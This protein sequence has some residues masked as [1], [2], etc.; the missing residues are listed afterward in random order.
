MEMNHRIDDP[1]FADILKRLRSQLL[2][3]TARNRLVKFRYTRRS[4]R[5]ID[6]GI[7]GPYRALL[8]GKTLKLCYVPLPY[9]ESSSITPASYAEKLGISIDYNLNA[10]APAD[11]LQTL[12]YPKDLDRITR[13]MLGENQLSLDETGNHILFLACGFLQYTFSQATEKDSEISTHTAPL[14]MLPVQLQKETIDSES[15]FY[16]FHLAALDTDEEVRDNITLREK[17][18][19]EFGFH[20]PSFKE[21]QSPNEY[22]EEVASG[23]GQ[24]KGWKVFPHLS[25]VLLSFRKLALWTDLDPQQDQKLLDHPLIKKLF[26]FDVKEGGY[27]NEGTSTEY[28]IDEHPLVDMSC[29]YDMDSSQ[30]SALIDALEGKNMVIVGPPGTGKSQTIT[31]L[32]ATAMG[33]RKSVLFVSEKKAALDVV[34]KRLENA[35]VGSFCLELHSNKT[36]K[37]NVIESIGKRLN[38]KFSKLTTDET[39][40]STLKELRDRL[41]AYVNFINREVEIPGNLST[42]NVFWKTEQARQMLECA[43]VDITNQLQNILWP[44]VLQWQTDD[45]RRRRQLLDELKLYHNQLNVSGNL[46]D[47]PLSGLHISSLRIDR[48]QIEGNI[49]FA[50]AA[51][52]NICD[53]SKTI[54]KQDAGLDETDV[55]SIEQYTLYLEKLQQVSRISDQAATFIKG[56]K[57][58]ALEGSSHH[59]QIA[60]TLILSIADNLLES[61][62]LFP[63]YNNNINHLSLTDTYV[64]DIPLSELVDLVQQMRFALDRIGTVLTANRPASQTVSL[65]ALKKFADQLGSNSCLLSLSIAELQNEL[66]N[67]RIAELKTLIAEQ[68]DLA[69]QFKFDRLPSTLDLD[70]HLQLIHGANWWKW[71]VWLAPSTKNAKKV[72]K[73]LLVNPFEAD[74][75]PSANFERL[76]LWCKKRDKFLDE[77]KDM[78]T[79][80]HWWNHA[81]CFAT[82]PLSDKHQNPFPILHGF[83]R[84]MEA[85]SSSDIIITSL[86][87]STFIEA[88]R[89]LI[90]CLERLNPPEELLDPDTPWSKLKSWL[91]H[92]LERLHTLIQE[93][94]TIA[95]NSLSLRQ[96]SSALRA[97]QKAID[98]VA[99]A[100]LDNLLSSWNLSLQTIHVE[101]FSFYKEALTWLLAIKQTN[102]A[103]AMQ[104]QVFANPTELVTF[105]DSLKQIILSAQQLRDVK[106]QLNQCGIEGLAL[107]LENEGIKLQQLHIYANRLEKILSGMNDL[108]TWFSYQRCRQTGKSLGLLEIIARLESGHII[109][110]QVIWAFNYVYFQSCIHQIYQKFPELASNSGHTLNWVRQKFSELDHKIIKSNGQRLAMD[111]SRRIVPEGRRAAK[112]SEQTDLVLLKHELGKARRHL[113]IRQLMIQAGKAIQALKPCFLMSPLSVAQFLPKT[114]LNFDILVIDEASQMRLPEAL[115]CLLRSKQI[116]VVGDPKQLPPSDFFDQIQGAEDEE[117]EGE[118]A[119]EDGAQSILERC[120]QVFDTPRHLRWHYRSQHHN[121]ITFS[122]YHFYD[123]RLIVLPANQ[124]QTVGMGVHYHYVEDAIY[125]SRTNRKEAQEVVAALVNQLLNDPI[126]SVGVV[127]LN[128]PQRE[129]ISELF[130]QQLRESSSLR[131]IVDGFEARGQSVFIKNLENVQ[132]DERDII[133][134]STV[135]GKQAGSSIVR[136]TFGPINGSSGWRRLN[137][138]FTR[139]RQRIE[140]YSSMQPEDITPDEKSSKGHWILRYYLEFAKNGQ[141]IRPEGA[142]EAENPF[143]EAIANLLNRNGYEVISQLGVK[144]YWIDIAVRHPEKPTEYL[145]AIEC[146]GATYHSS[147]SARDR[148]RIRQ[149]LLESMG[150]KGKIYRIW[151]TDWFTSPAKQSELLLNFLASLRFTERIVD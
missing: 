74:A 20:L 143:E 60:L 104:K 46:Q 86:P 11:R 146:D 48:R 145:A 72:C 68:V 61:S 14:L 94:Q 120:L 147:R 115:G 111:I 132:G 41:T 26:G 18:R 10:T 59:V 117:T 131:E 123:E 42:H 140:L 63:N 25:L 30:H 2:D 58:K 98:L 100:Q 92:H 55:L 127:A 24:R 90:T 66:R 148:D 105:C 75:V 62:K 91:S 78:G 52:R 89:S 9:E 122:N 106:H 97:K 124:E 80:S 28:P 129:L 65:G 40:L 15:G 112:A 108:E 70:E 107:P 69:T 37:R 39:D 33:K 31:N 5:F 83:Y 135:Y 141:L 49:Q 113:P 47:H 51:I 137:V 16:T 119:I 35:G 126:N 138:L 136:Q 7:D 82:N 102:I 21:E 4:I 19:Q 125:L 85:I 87:M 1:F 44:E 57:D 32:I 99:H 81:W 22:L 6:V 134:I 128:Q 151:S 64:D 13:A 79:L 149:Q 144:G 29:I 50:I 142:G 3:L 36:C 73:D 84:E 109:A 45:L 114:A 27:G 95:S 116:V 103:H 23:C 130:Q 76:L 54:I 93:C 38:A 101:H 118:G 67:P 12:L 88:Y 8:E 53:A 139:A 56:L 77:A 43:N 150:W 34:L 17:L 121:L 96:V 110:S 71:W 133:F